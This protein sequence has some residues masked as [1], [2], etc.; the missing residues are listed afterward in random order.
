M[1]EDIA[2]GTYSIKDVVLPLP[3]NRI[4]YPS[5]SAGDEYRRKLEEVG[6]GECNFR[7]PALK[8]NIP[9]DYRKFVVH[10]QRTW[11]GNYMGNP[12]LQKNTVEIS[13]SKTNKPWPDPSISECTNATKPSARGCPAFSDISECTP[14]PGTS[15]DKCHH[16]SSQT[17]QG[18]IYSSTSNETQNLPTERTLNLSFDLPS[19]CYA[20][21]FLRELMKTL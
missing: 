7:L 3:G 5:N 4:Q 21:M 18:R 6:L 1:K 13:S 9:G 2:K 20:T 16:P 15:S 10:S 19:S 11:H 12:P 8:L 17:M 14:D